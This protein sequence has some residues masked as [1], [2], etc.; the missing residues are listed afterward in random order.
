M[1]YSHYVG[2][3]VRRKEDPRL[4]TGSSTYVGDVKLP[5]M[6]HCAILRSPY[7]HAR[8]NG[9][10][11]SAALAHPRRRRGLHRRADEEDGRPDGRRRRRGRRR[12]GGRARGRSREAVGP[13]RQGS[14]IS[15]RRRQS[16]PCRRAGRGGD[17]HGYVHGARRRGHDRGG[18]GAAA[19]RRHAR[20]GDGAG[21]A[22]T[23]RRQAGQ[24]RPAL[25]EDERRC[26]CRLRR[27]GEGRRRPRPPYRQPAARRRADGGARRLRR[28]GRLAGHADRLELQPE[29]A[30]RPLDHRAA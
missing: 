5:G 19:R 9:I 11:A 8:I 15:P 13:E 1:V 21:R 20:S 2:A 24:Y 30:Q 10:D 14:A 4:I 27:G 6:L 25:G 29:P 18:L 26:G 7:A 12:R 22:A 3:R 28:M 17:R 16:A 23:L